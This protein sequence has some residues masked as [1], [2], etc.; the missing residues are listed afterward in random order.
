MRWKM[1]WNRQYA[2]KSYLQGSLWLA[3][4][5]AVVLFWVFSRVMSAISGWLMRSGLIDDT[6]A[7]MGLGM[8][9]ARKLLETITTAN[10]SFL[11]FT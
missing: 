9:G 7:F 3:P 2:I 1:G 5:F 11:V 10:L 6:T 8:T 4:F